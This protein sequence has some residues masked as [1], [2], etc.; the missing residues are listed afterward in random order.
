MR[1]PDPSKPVDSGRLERRSDGQGNR[2]DT[3][4][5]GHSAYNCPPQPKI[6]IIPLRI[7][8]TARAEKSCYI[9]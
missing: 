4:G 9:W 1:M 8:E 6:A 7:G 5:Q 3:R 2:V